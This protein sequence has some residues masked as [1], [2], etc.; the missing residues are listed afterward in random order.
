MTSTATP[1]PTSV[2]RYY[3][4]LGALIYVGITSRG[5]RRN[6]EHNSKV[7]WRFVVRQEVDHY[8][9]RP[10]AEKAEKAL[11]RQYLP[12]FNTKHNPHH[13]ELRQEY[14]SWADFSGGVYDPPATFRQLNRNLPL[15]P[16]SLGE[17]DRFLLRTLPEHFAV[18]RNLI[19]LKSLD[20]FAPKS[21]GKV[22]HDQM[23]GRVRHLVVK[24]SAEMPPVEFA[25][26]MAALRWAQDPAKPGGVTSSFRLKRI[27]LY[28]LAAT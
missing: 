13:A 23:I 11:I 10:A 3:D 16:V 8:P 27:E 14:L 7:W 22:E 20:V 17:P 4:A 28:Q 25:I 1:T 5:I 12:P 9:S 19:K 18:A 6:D 24:T 15:E 2:Y 26:A 21:I